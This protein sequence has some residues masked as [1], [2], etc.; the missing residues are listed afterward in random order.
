MGISRKRLLKFP[1]RNPRTVIGKTLCL[2]DL[3]RYFAL[4]H[5]RCGWE[6]E[7]TDETQAHEDFRFE[8]ASLAV[9]SKKVLGS[10]FK[11]IYF[12][13]AFTGKVAKALQDAGYEVKASDLSDHW[14][15]HMRSQGLDAERRSFEQMPESSFDA[16]ISFEPFPVYNNLVG[17]MGI[18]RIMASSIPF[19]EISAEPH[20]GCPPVRELM[21][22]GKPGAL[23]QKLKQTTND[24]REIAGRMYPV[25]QDNMIFRTT[26]DYGARFYHHLVYLDSRYSYNFYASVPT[27]NV[28]DMASLDL[29]ILDGHSREPFN[30][31]LS[32]G[33]LART[34]GKSIHEISAAVF[35]LRNILNMRLGMEVG[36]L[37]ASVAP[38]MGRYCGNLGEEY[39]DIICRVQIVE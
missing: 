29:Q 12:P 7:K 28:A 27:D 39:P 8:G 15:R 3:K 1:E 33:M 16:V 30:G 10:G 26:Y 38:P 2:P 14:V 11:R 4:V 22:K 6:N 17:L 21:L 23:K 36:Y 34:L 31:S 13:L 32:L 24:G 18:M 5:E 35:R 9:Y 37:K 19:I 25:L 20:F